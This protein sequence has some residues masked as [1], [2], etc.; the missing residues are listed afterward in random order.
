M[1]LGQS[2]QLPILPLFPEWQSCECLI[3][4]VSGP[5]HCLLSLAARDLNFYIKYTGFI[6]SGGWIFTFPLLPQI[7]FSQFDSVKSDRDC[8]LHW[9]NELSPAVNSQPWGSEEDK[10][11]LSLAQTHQCHNWHIVA[12]ELEVCVC[13]CTNTRSLLHMVLSRITLT[14][15]DKPHCICLPEALPAKFKSQHDKIVSAYSIVQ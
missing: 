10:L 2:K 7:D 15:T 12:R 9:E 4:D 11:L 14:H 1:Y 6:S 13:V 5:S 3:E 8:Q